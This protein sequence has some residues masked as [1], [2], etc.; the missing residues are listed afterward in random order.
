[1]FRKLDRSAVPDLLKA[2]VVL[3]CLPARLSATELAYGGESPAPLPYG[4]YGSYGYGYGMSPTPIP[5]VPTT[6]APTTPAPTTPAPTTP[7]PTTPATTTPAPTTPVPTS[8]IPGTPTPPCD[9]E[10]QCRQDCETLVWQS[11]LKFRRVERCALAC[12]YAP[13]I[14]ACASLYTN[15]T[16]NCDC[17]TCNARKCF[18]R[19]ACTDVVCDDIACDS[20]CS[21]LA[22][23]APL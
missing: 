13:C 22:A 2:A 8:S 1:M 14:G 9:C 21:T 19:P 16:N 23:A 20:G 7:A 10:L 3:L 11:A 12:T 5:H 18:W 6:P 17:S 4:T 15:S